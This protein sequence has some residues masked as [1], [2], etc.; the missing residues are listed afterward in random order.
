MN[1]QVDVET[2]KELQ[3]QKRLN[4]IDFLL[5]FRGWFTRQDLIEEFKIA[6]AGATRDVAKYRELT[7]DSD[8]SSKADEAVSYNLRFDDNLK[9]YVAK[10]SYKALH[11]L[12]FAHASSLLKRNIARNRLGATSPIPVEFPERLIH[13][14]TDIL[15]SL[16]RCIGSKLTCETKYQSRTSVEERT[17]CPHSF[18]ESEGKWY[19]RAYCLKRNEFRTFSLTRFIYAMPTQDEQ[20]AAADAEN[21]KQWQ[22][23]ILLQIIPHSSLDQAAQESLRREYSMSGEYKEISVRAAISVF[24]LSHWRVDCSA[25]GK[26]GEKDKHYQLQLKNRD[27]LDDVESAKIAPGYES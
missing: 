2:S 23:K 25:D 5:G 27:V 6:P 13:P 24:W 11:E 21:D 10:N 4:F 1:E 20:P 16:S 8:L 18:F 22:T 15:S 17:I 12:S 9:R 3:Q 26:L 14:N 7:K 19:I